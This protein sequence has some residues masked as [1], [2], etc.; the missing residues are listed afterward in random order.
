MGDVPCRGCGILLTGASRLRGVCDF[1]SRAGWAEA[2]RWLSFLN[3]TAARYRMARIQ[4]H[5]AAPVV[6]TFQ[7]TA[8]GTGVTA[9]MPAVNALVALTT[10]YA[11]GRAA[12]DR[13]QSLNACPFEQDALVNEWVR[14]WKAGERAGHP[15]ED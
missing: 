2:G 4:E 7:I 3:R 1:C 11:A 6:R 15:A 9:H 14:G 8:E 10:P 5:R 13:G 12:N